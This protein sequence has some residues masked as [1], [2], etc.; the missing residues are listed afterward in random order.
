[1]EDETLAKY[2]R[3]LGDPTRVRIVELLREEKRSV[4]ALTRVLAASQSKVSTH[5]ACLPALV[6]G[7]S[8]RAGSIPRSTTEFPTTAWSS[9]SSSRTGPTTTMSIYAPTGASTG[10]TRDRAAL[11][12][13]MQAQGRLGRRWRRPGRRRPRRGVAAM[14]PPAAWP[15]AANAGPRRCV[16][17]DD[18]GRGRLA[19][20]HAGAPCVSDTP[21]LDPRSER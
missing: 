7:S 16:R 5:P 11:F 8:T 4:G 18:G 15:C 17:A 21:L 2:V 14:G 12:G 20:S 10:S 19:G 3:G 13:S 1:M 9:G 6:R